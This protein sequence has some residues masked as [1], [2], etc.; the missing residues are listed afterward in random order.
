M[1]LKQL[2]MLAF[3]TFVAISSV[4]AGEHSH[5]KNLNIE[6]LET[7]AEQGDVSAQ[8]ELGVMY[9]DGSGAD[10]DMSKAKYYLDKAIKNSNKNDLAFADVAKIYWEMFEL[11]KY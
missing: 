10:K 1:S 9:V 5:G 7:L 3:L 6:H 11:W 2:S 8:Y 4:Q